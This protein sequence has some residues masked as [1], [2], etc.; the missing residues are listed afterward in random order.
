MIPK[1]KAHEDI[2]SPDKNEQVFSEKRGVLA[3]MLKG[4]EETPG[5]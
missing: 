4:K 1:N 5:R 2:S 3:R